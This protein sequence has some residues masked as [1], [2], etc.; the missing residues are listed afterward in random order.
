MKG[1]SF[2]AVYLYN[3]KDDDNGYMFDVEYFKFNMYLNNILPHIKFWLHV[4]QATFVYEQDYMFLYFTIQTV[5]VYEI[6]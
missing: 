3:L 4:H 2:I 5:F 1:I 6:A